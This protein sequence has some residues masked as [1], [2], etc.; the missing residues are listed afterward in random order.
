VDTRARDVER[1]ARSGDLGAAQSLFRERLRIGMSSV[2][3][4]TIE[5]NVETIDTGRTLLP[6]KWSMDYESL[7]GEV[8]SAALTDH[9]GS[10]KNNELRRFEC[11]G[12]VSTLWA[13]TA[14]AGRPVKPVRT[15]HFPVTELALAVSDG[16]RTCIWIAQDHAVET[17]THRRCVVLPMGLHGSDGLAH[18]LC[19]DLWDGRIKNKDRLAAARTHLVKRFL[20]GYR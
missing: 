17:L 15:R 20:R 4:R 1:L 14:I 5:G 2:V 8:L 12:V 19:M 9:A 3:Y 13:K 10:P 7:G 6:P 11:E 16:E 18:G